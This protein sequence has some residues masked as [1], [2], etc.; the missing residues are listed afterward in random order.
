MIENSEG[1]RTS[2]AQTHE[3]KLY[4]Y[5]QSSLIPF[6]LSL[7]RSLNYTNRLRDPSAIPQS[8]LRDFEVQ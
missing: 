2:V 7:P 6:I 8:T 3:V 4:I 1:G 5:K